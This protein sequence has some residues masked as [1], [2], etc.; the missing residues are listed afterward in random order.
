[1]GKTNLEVA[2]AKCFYCG[3]DG[4]IYLNTKL[5]PLHAAHVKDMHGKVCSMTPCNACKDKMQ[6][7]V[8]LIEIDNSLSEPDWHQHNLPDPYRTGR[9]LWMKEE[10]FKCTITGPCLEFGL[11]HRFTFINVGIIKE[12]K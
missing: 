12:N 2:L 8:L 5:T 3:G 10:A 9:L 4:E 7:Y 1:M 11:K 6:D